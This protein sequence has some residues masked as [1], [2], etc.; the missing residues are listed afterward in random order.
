MLQTVIMVEGYKI[1]SGVVL[2]IRNVFDPRKLW[3][4][5]FAK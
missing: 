5:C 3:E 4:M 1:L 2:E